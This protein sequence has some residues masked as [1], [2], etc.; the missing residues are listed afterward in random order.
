MPHTQTQL[1]PNPGRLLALGWLSVVLIQI[2]LG[3]R[4]DL[5]SD[6][7]FYWFAS[8]RPA[9]AYSDLPFM[10]AWLAGIGDA[11]GVHHPLAVRAPF[12]ILGA[13][14]PALIYWV[15]QPLTGHRPA[16]ESALLSL[17]VPLLGFAGLLAVPDVPLL[18]CGLLSMG[19]FHR[20]ITTQRGYWWLAAGLAA[21]AGFSTHYRFAPY[22]AAALIWLLTT[23]HGRLQWRKPGPWMATGLAVSGLVPL[24][25][26]NL[27]QSLSG[28]DYHLLDRHPWAFDWQGLLHL[29]K[30]AGLVTPPLYILLLAT[31][32]SLVRRARTG[33]WEAQ[34]LLSFSLANLLPYLVL[35]PWADATRTSIHWPLSGYL[36]LLIGLPGTLEDLHQLLLRRVTKAAALRL[37][38]SIPLIGFT[39]TLV[40]LLGVGSQAWHEPLQPW[41]GAGILSNKM[42]GWTSFHRHTAEHLLDAESALDLVITDNYYTAAQVAFGVGIPVTVLTTDQD[43]S[44]RD[45]RQAQLALWEMDH[46]ALARFVGKDALFIA[47]DSS[48]TVPEKEAIIAD[49]CRRAESVTWFDRL[50]SLGEEKRFSYFRV[51]GL[52]ANP[53]PSETLPAHCPMPPRAWI[54]VPGPDSTLSAPIYVQGWAYNESMGIREILLVLDGTVVGT[55][56]Y[57]IPRPDVVAAM[58]VR[59]DPKAPNLGFSLRLDADMLTPGHHLLSL[60]LVSESGE[61]QRYGEREIWIRKD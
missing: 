13:T 46:R 3:A 48:L 35:A 59:S 57:G 44:I 4:L 60:L 30:Q 24:L 43:K 29:F 2:V 14:I 21:A 37:T 51:Q 7:I 12:L 5:Y 28:L 38:R 11:L 56:Q 41:L 50:W 45:G 39:G 25:H 15:A 20:A 54:D 16:L 26:F 40:A 9:W 52:L 6:E 58:G 23:R 34:F 55:A 27:T 53:Q 10:A 36:P 8:T 32:W 18:V 33:Q 31:L 1:L 22:A 17:C 47:E 61:Q 19:C 42:A 49:L